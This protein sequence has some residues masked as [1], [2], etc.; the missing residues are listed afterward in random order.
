MELQQ[1]N[2][3]LVKKVCE[4][5]EKL[6]K[7]ETLKHCNEIDN[8]YNELVDT[9][10]L[11]SSINIAA[12]PENIQ[13]LRSKLIRLCGEVETQLEVHFSMILG[14]LKNPLHHLNI[15]PNHSNHLKLT[16]VEYNLLNQHYSTTTQAPKQLAFVG[17]GPLPLTSILLASYHLK[18]TTF[19]NYDIDLSANSM[20]SPLV[21][22]DD[23]LSKRM[24]FHTTDIVD[25]TDELKDYDVIFLVALVG[26]DVD[27]KVKVIQRL[28]KFMAPGAIVML[29]SAHGT[30]AFLYPVVDPYVLQGLDILTIFHPDDHGRNDD[31]INSVVISRKYLKP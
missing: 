1:E 4:I 13:E 25:V 23:D 12:L 11:H 21:A 8:L 3:T 2:I 24:F 28:A 18:E 27:E 7:F 22:S 29:R 16:R 31:V 14:S 20:A 15:F 10:L 9:C 26:M 17:S 19:H 30:R 5:Y 6:S